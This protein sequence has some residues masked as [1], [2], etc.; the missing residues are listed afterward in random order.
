MSFTSCGFSIRLDR[1]PLLG[2]LIHT[3]GHKASASRNLLQS[4]ALH[5]IQT[6]KFSEEGKGHKLLAAGLVVDKTF[7]PALGV[8]VS[9]SDKLE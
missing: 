7:F 6:L 3:N 8:G 4:S 9:G 1:P 5:Q 2:C